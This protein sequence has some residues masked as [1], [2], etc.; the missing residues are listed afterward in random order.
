MDPRE[1]L[2]G[3]GKLYLERGEPI[4]LTLLVEAEEMGLSLTE[5]GQPKTLNKE[6]EGEF[7]NE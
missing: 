4:P 5:F 1:R 3:L 2:L 7:D 6:E